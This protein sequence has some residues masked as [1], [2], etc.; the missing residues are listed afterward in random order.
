MGNGE[1]RW[2]WEKIPYI[3]YKIDNRSLEGKKTTVEWIIQKS[4]LNKKNSCI[5]S[6]ELWMYNFKEL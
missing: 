1:W 2:D 6:T 5:D 4:N 3:L